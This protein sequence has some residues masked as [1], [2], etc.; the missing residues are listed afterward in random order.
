[1]T[2]QRL[3]V[4]RAAFRRF[5]SEPPPDPGSTGDNRRSARGSAS[6]TSNYPPFTGPG[7]LADRNTPRGTAS[8]PGGGRHFKTS[9]AGPPRSWL[10]ELIDS[11]SRRRAQ[12]SS[13]AE[14]TV[15][16]RNVRI[17]QPIVSQSQSKKRLRFTW[18]TAAGNAWSLLDVHHETC[19]LLSQRFFT[20]YYTFHWV[21]EDFYL[22]FSQRNKCSVTGKQN[23]LKAELT[24]SKLANGRTPLIIPMERYF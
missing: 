18:L 6:Q 19:E 20:D 4:Q 14:M 23:K 12:P 16:T 13:D 10:A 21:W 8:R 22:F 9:R 7:R 1:M 24:F 11:S 3:D 2:F 15:N 5:V 17:Y